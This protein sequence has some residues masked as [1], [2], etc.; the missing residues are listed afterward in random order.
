LKKNQM[1]GTGTPN[2]NIERVNMRA[3]TGTKND[4]IKTD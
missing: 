3:E 2:F 1:M 4:K